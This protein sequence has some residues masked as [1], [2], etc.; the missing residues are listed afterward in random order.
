MKRP[1]RDTRYGRNCRASFKQKLTQSYGGM[2]KFP[3]IRVANITVVTGETT[4]A[5]IEHVQ[6]VRLGRDSVA[7]WREEHP[8]E[9]PDLINCMMSHARIPMVDLH[10]C[11]MRAPALT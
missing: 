10:N 7:K 2:L 5:N 1:A 11:D 8:G 6:I 9:N 4:M 3:C